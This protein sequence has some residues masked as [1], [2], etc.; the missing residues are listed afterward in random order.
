MKIYDITAEISSNLPVYGNERPEI[1]ITS[2]MDNGDPYNF[3]KIS[4]TAHT[5]THADMP[6]HFIPGGSTCTDTA[7]DYFYGPAKVMRITVQGHVRKAD[8]EPLDIREGDIVL[9]DTG[10]SAYM[11]QGVLNQDFIALT[12]E[13]AEYL[14]MK[15]IKTIGIDYLSIDPYGA[16][17]FP[18]HKALLGNGIAVLEGLVL[19]NVPE[20]E[21]I[22]SALPLKIPGGEGSPVRAILVDNTKK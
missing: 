8:L 16:E 9:L 5:G 18:A 22:L 17:G 4:V 3:S 11:R 10:Q 19:E 7:L 13:A 1:T 20:G 21:Y 12:P 2:Q 15:K 6:L 14:V